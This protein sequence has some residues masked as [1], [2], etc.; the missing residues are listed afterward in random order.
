MLHT[1][2]LAFKSVTTLLAQRPSLPPARP[3]PNSSPQHSKPLMTWLQ[4]TYL[5]LSPTTP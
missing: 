3:N 5:T 2:N 4:G 1:D